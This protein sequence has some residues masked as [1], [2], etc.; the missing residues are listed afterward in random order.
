MRSAVV[1]LML[2][3]RELLH[4]VLGASGG[5]PAVELLLVRM[6]AAPELPI[7]FGAPPRDGPVGDP[8]IVE[9]R[10]E[11]SPNWMATGR[12]RRSYSM[13][14]MADLIELGS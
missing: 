5:D 9:V 14:A 3:L 7:A 1:V 6:M 12:R 2:P 4:Q 11:V 13:K 8:Q 10:G